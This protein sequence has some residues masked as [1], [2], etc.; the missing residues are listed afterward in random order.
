MGQIFALDTIYN[1]L[2]VNCD[3]GQ[4]TPINGFDDICVANSSITI[5]TAKTCYVQ[6]SMKKYWNGGLKVLGSNFNERSQ[7]NV[8][9]PIAMKL[10]I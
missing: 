1:F 7:E 3:F 4:K 8:L 2:K 10:K 9:F 6:N 5:S